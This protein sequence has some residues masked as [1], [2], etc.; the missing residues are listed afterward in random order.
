MTLN[1]EEE[2]QQQILLVLMKISKIKNF[3][4]PLSHF[5]SLLQTSI[6]ILLVEFD[7]IKIFKN[8]IAS[9]QIIF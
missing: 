2:N 8:S 3:F 4:S 6:L 7:V 9:K 1:E 5:S